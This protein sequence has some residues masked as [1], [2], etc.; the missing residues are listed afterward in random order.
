MQRDRPRLGAGILGA[1]RRERVGREPT[2]G[3]AATTLLLVLAQSATA[4]VPPATAGAPDAGVANGDTG[5][6][7][8]WVGGLFI[9][10]LSFVA[11]ELFIPSGGVLG[12]VAFLCAIAAVVMGFRVGVTAGLAAMGTLVAGG[13]AA[14]WAALRVFPHTPIGRRI[15]LSADTSEEDLQRRKY[16]KTQQSQAISGLIGAR[17]VAITELRP[18]GTI[19]IDGQD[20]EAFAETGMIHGDTPVEVVNVSGRHIRVRPVT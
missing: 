18:G 1:G 3:A 20:L 14:I 12:T 17:G 8:L 15:I 13:P 10:A 7:L 9:L 4:F 16:E 11:L 5:L 2:P 19:R 6:L